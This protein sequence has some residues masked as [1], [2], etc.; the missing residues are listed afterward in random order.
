M[1]GESGGGG[2]KGG[3]KGNEWGGGILNAFKPGFMK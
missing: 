2:K 3:K 1:V